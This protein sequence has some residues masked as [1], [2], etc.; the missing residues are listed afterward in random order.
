MSEMVDEK[1]EKKAP[2]PSPAPVAAS[3]G[4]WIPKLLKAVIVAAGAC[5][6]VTAMHLVSQFEALGPAV[7]PIDARDLSR[8]REKL[9]YA[10]F[11]VGLAIG[12]AAVALTLRKLGGRFP[13]QKLGQ[14]T[15][16]RVTALAAIGALSAFG[17][18]AFYRMPPST[19]SWWPNIWQIPVLG[20]EIPIKPVLFPALALFFS[21][22][23]SVYL[24]L[25]QEKWAEFLVETEGELKKVSWPARKEY[26]GSAS[27][28]VVVVAIVSVFLFFTDKALSV[29][30]QKIGIGF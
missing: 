2:Q 9:S 15:A 4:E 10:G 20:H 8:A 16:V 22:M 12:V 11:G 17:C 1:D 21:L 5:W 19:S 28:V 30:M 23:V 24:L 13:Y 6:A 25:N 14:G 29:L 3:K 18:Y 26:V 7:V 27:V